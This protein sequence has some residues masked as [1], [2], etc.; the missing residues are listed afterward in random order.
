MMPCDQSMIFKTSAGITHISSL[1]EFGDYYGP[2][3]TTNFVLRSP[4]AS[5]RDPENVIVRRIQHRI[6]LVFNWFEVD[7]LGVYSSKT[8]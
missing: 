7:R 2:L 5:A 3:I 6:Y 4:L 8:N 1:L